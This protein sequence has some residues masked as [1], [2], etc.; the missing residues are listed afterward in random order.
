VPMLLGGDELGRSQSGNNNAYCHDSELSWYDWAAVDEPLLDFTRRLIVL[1]RAHPVF[2]RRRWFLDGHPGPE[3][4]QGPP[5]IAW[6]HPRGSRMR[7]EE[8]HTDAP[9]AIAV[10]LSGRHLVDADG[11]PI[12][13]DS[14]YL[15][16]NAGSADL[17]FR[18][19][20]EDL[21]RGWGT[22]LDTAATEPF[23]PWAGPPRAAG[24][25]LL[26]TAHSLVL[27]RLVESA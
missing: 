22:V 8:W 21:G 9:A 1:R 18:M 24:Q 2:R 12:V 13:D 15:C 20:G 6:C 11:R 7:D 16:L 27:L 17:E 23:G 25:A 4:E 26:V 5:D 3:G 14:F 19:P 10:Y